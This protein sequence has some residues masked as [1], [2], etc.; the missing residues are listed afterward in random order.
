L[1]IQPFEKIVD[2]MIRRLKLTRRTAL[3]GLATGGLMAVQLRA[4]AFALPERAGDHELAEIGLS[5][6]TSPGDVRRVGMTCQGRTELCLSRE[7]LVDSIFGSECDRLEASRDPAQV[8]GWLRD[9]IREDFSVGRTVAVD[10]WVLANTE[11]RLYAL[12]AYA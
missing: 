12:A 4:R 9:R 3:D 5:M 8:H 2:Y 6:F 11:A 1:K 7:A 10:G